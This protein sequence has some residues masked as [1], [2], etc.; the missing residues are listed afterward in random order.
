MHASTGR[1]APHTAP[2]SPSTS[3]TLG[4]GKAAGERVRPVEPGLREGPADLHFGVPAEPGGTQTPTSQMTLGRQAWDQ[5]RS[6]RPGDGEQAECGPAGRPG[7][8]RSRPQLTEA[9]RPAGQCWTCLPPPRAHRTVTADQTPRERLAPRG[10]RQWELTGWRSCTHDPGD[11][12]TAE[13]GSRQD[14][15]CIPSPSLTQQTRAEEAER[16]SRG[17]S[18]LETQAANVRKTAAVSSRRGRPADI[19]G[20]GG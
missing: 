20:V 14:N 9:S 1:C 17:K 4:H 7:S 19:A 11:G 12:A 18:C 10:G 8:L 5:D 13:P 2:R 3:P 6:G 16:A 15:A